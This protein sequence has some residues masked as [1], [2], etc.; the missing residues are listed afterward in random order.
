VRAFSVVTLA[1]VVAVACGRAPA[2]PSDEVA[3]TWVGSVS[4]RTAGMGTLTLHLT[5]DRG[6]VGGTW[7]MDFAADGNDRNGTV[8]GSLIGP[9]LVAGLTPDSPFVC[10]SDPAISGVLTLT[11]TVV[12]S[13]L[14]GS[15][16]GF[17]CGAVLSGAVDLDH[18]EP[19]DAASP[20]DLAAMASILGASGVM[21]MHAARWSGSISVNGGT[22]EVHSAM[23]HGHRV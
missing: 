2:A 21:R 10:A 18:L 16:A 17:G 3:G 6:G 19:S 11:A 13:K 4:D 1:A 7:A 9:R 14:S 12:G 22:T 5:T 8:G 23:A 15:Y 20:P